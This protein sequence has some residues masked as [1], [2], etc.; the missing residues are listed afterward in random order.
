M[1]PSI[2]VLTFQHPMRV[3][4]FIAKVVNSE[5]VRLLCVASDSVILG[6]KYE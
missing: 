2:N 6:V 4:D 1:P 5:R 3:R